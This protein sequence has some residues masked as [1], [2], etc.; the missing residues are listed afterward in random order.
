MAGAIAA[1]HGA[2]EAAMTIAGVGLV[3]GAHIINLRRTPCC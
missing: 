2:G 3:A 1:E